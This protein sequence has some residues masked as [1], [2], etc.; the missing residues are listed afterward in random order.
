VT[1]AIAESRPY[2]DTERAAASSSVRQDA[3]TRGA[4]RIKPTP[5]SYHSWKRQWSLNNYGDV[6]PR[7]SDDVAAV[8]ARR[9]SACQPRLMSP[10]APATPAP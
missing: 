1:D 8:T 6:Y 4:A 9:T 2:P 10:Y 3:R 7:K 5:T